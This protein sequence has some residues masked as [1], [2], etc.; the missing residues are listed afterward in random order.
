MKD[1]KQMLQTILKGIKCLYV[2]ILNK[3]PCTHFGCVMS[4]MW[5]FL[6]E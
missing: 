2:T 1:L 3:L 5:R 4:V 6:A